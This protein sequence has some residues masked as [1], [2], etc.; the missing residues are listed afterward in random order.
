MTDD[1]S[2]IATCP[3]RAAIAGNPSDGYGGAVLS[4]PLD[5]LVASAAG[6]PAD[7][8]G[9]DAAGDDVHRLL[10]ATSDEFEAMVGRLP[11]LEL[12]ASTTIPRSVGLAGSSALILAALRV[13]AA[14]TSTDWTPLDLAGAALRIERDRLSIVGGK[15]DPVVQAAGRPVLM[16][17]A[18]S[19][20]L[21]AVTAVEFGPEIA[22]FVAWDAGYTESSD[23][24]HTILRRR[25]SD[26]SRAPLIDEL[27]RQAHAAVAAIRRRDVGAFAATINRTFDL[28]RELT[29]ID[30]RQIRLVEIG[31]E[32]GAATNSAGSGGSV[33]GLAD[34]IADLSTLRSVYDRAGCGFLEIY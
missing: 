6:R 9:I 30:R 20:E 11:P 15:Q 13:L 27:A 14:A 34:T 2:I 21:A 28:R 17:F 22:L 4:T 26:P 18:S 1:A 3:A 23:V 8:F 31:R 32:A 33:I 16:D 5:E 29:E 19:D 12:S 10:D 24:A 25:A 7:R